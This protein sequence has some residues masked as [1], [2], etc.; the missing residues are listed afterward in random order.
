MNEQQKNL[1]MNKSLLDVKIEK[2]FTKSFKSVIIG[3]IMVMV[4]ATLNIMIYASKAGVGV[5]SSFS[6]SVGMILLIGSVIVNI[7]L[8]RNVAKNLTT[9]LV[10]PIQELRVA[11]QKLKAGEFDVNI[12]YK[13]KDELGDLANDLRQACEQIIL[14]RH[15]KLQQ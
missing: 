13:G 15:K 11:V 1:K 10:V 6:R 12:Q 3:F 14:L 7:L 5:F 8:I 4:F 9:A 2:K